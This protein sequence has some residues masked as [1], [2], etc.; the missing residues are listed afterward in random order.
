VTDKGT[1]VVTGM[2]LNFWQQCTFRAAQMHPDWEA[3]AQFI[4]RTRFRRTG[5]RTPN[6]LLNW[7]LQNHP[8]EA[9]LITR[10]IKIEGWEQREPQGR[11]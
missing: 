11:A 7:F 8:Q 4:R 2:R 6:G 3:N 5:P 1:W 10:R 9:D